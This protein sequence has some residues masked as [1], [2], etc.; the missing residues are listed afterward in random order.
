V[1][2]SALGPGP[3]ASMLLADHGAEVI[4]VERPEP[5]P[6]ADWFTRGKRS[7]VADLRSPEG[8]ELVRRLVDGA[9]VF[10]EGNRP[11]VL[12]RRGLGPDVLMARNPRLIYVRMTG[13]GQDG[14]Y[15]M[16]AGHDI[17]YIAIGGPLGV[18]GRTEPVPPLNMLGDFAGGSLLA[19]QGVFM[20]LYERERTGRGQVVDAAIVD[21]AA[22]LAY[23]QLAQYSRGTWA[24]RGVDVLSGNAPFYGTYECADGRYFSVGA[25]EPK[26]YVA[27]LDVLGLEADLSD[28]FNIEAWPGRRKRIAE[29][30]ATRTREQWT[31]VFATADACA[32][33]VL[34]LDELEHDPHLRERGVI[35]RD[36]NRIES[37]PAPRLSVTP[38]SLRL[39]RRSRGDDTRAVLA[40]NGF[41]A[42]EVER[43]TAAWVPA[44]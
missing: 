31:E 9:D 42:E 11:G 41:S 16:R 5:D 24:G 29:V 23:A 30:F 4:S 1:D 7:V 27:L 19:V 3:F 40:E 13:Y 20:A 25:F 26:F 43:L 33:P 35:V 39:P 8:V 44:D 22:Q 17:N 28:Q 38:G 15:A 18:I 2:V 14:P 10:I 36:G 32:E 37:G 34:G 6:V 21:G 12:E